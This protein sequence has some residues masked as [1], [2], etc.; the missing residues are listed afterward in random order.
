M[1]NVEECIE[2]CNKAIE[3]ITVPSGDNN[4][5]AY[6]HRKA[7][8]QGLVGF[9]ATIFFTSSKNDLSI[10]VGKEKF[11]LKPYSLTGNSKLQLIKS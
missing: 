5:Y 11:K 10:K 2:S 8:K 4:E 9:D 3:A 1:S 6:L 7:I